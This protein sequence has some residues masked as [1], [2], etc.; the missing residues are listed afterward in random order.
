MAADRSAALA[1]EMIKRGQL[2]EPEDDNA[3]FYVQQA[4]KENPRSEAGRASEE[5]LASALLAAARAAID[6]RDFSRASGLLDAADA[7]A[8]PASV[9]ELRQSLASARTP[10]DRG[11]EMLKS[12]EQSLAE[13]RLVEPPSNNTAYY[14]TMLRKVDPENPRLSQISDD[15]GARLVAKA[16]AAVGARDFEAARAWL[17][18]ASSIGYA[19][20]QA[21]V[22]RRDL[23]AAL[24]S[25]NRMAE[26]TSANQ[27]ELVKS[28]APVYPAKAEK[29]GVEGWVDLE[30]T[31]SET[32]RVQDVAVSAASP[33]GIFDQAASA[34]L[35]QWRYKP[36]VLD[37]KPVARRARIRIRFELPH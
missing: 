8:A 27:L 20:P 29:S 37:A 32:G 4:L 14:L 2:I 23:E 13:D 26:V 22:V 10:G 33:K 12:A 19:S 31:V 28:V 25:G 7:I 21:E 9:E 36:F 24:E 30:F 15:L 18:H 3:R 16:R 1:M 35:L 5:A 34:A 6:R 17:G 11:S